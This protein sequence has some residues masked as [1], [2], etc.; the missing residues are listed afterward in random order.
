MKDPILDMDITKPII[1]IS[2]IN[3]VSLPSTYAVGCMETAKIN[4]QQ[5][6]EL[7][8]LG[9]TNPERYKFRRS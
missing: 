6:F 8:Q 3:T 4:D 5:R 2:Q 1:D 9:I 7:A